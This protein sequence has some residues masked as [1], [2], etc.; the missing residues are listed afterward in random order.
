VKLAWVTQV[1][2]LP[3]GNT[4]VVNCHAGPDQPQVVEVTPDKKVAWSFK[5]FEHFGNA[6]PVALVMDGEGKVVR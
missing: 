6:T 1:S 5:D 4:L 2:R 3:N